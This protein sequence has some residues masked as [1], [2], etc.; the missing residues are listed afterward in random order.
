MAAAE[1][2]AGEIIDAIEAFYPK[3]LAMDW[4]N[5][6][7]ELG[8]RSK[9]VNKV[10]L[11]LDATRRVVETAREQGAD[12]LITHHPMIFG[13]LRQIN[14]ESA[15]GRKLLELAE[16]RI[17]YYAMHTNYDAALEG[18]ARAAARR[19]GLGPKS[20]LEIT[21][22]QE[23]K[24]VGIGFIADLP[25]TE[26]AASLAA[27]CR[28]A[29]GLPAVWYYDGGRPIRT[30]AVCPGSGRHMLEAVR[31]AGAEA[32]ITGDTGHH[33]GM[34]Y[35]DERITLI[36]AGHFGLEQIFTDE[37]ERF[38]NTRF[39]GLVILKEETDERRY[40]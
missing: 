9:K 10:L 26:E 20:P 21:G 1:Q 3:E 37:M 11:A 17:A 2:T 31:A 19:L 8:R 15:L 36:D 34:D 23:E 5:P 33:D 30:V 29:F 12:L 6:G 22:T 24:D 16:H 38:L 14:E 40:V 39:P 32:F 35:F 28:D 18:M 4:D 25:E 7:L 27:K 13:S